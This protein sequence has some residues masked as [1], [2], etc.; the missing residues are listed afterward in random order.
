VIKAVK[1]AQNLAKK[2]GKNRNRIHKPDITQGQDIKLNNAGAL[3]A[4]SNSLA[5]S[6]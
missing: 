4:L 5:I 3:L 6:Q 1:I 2:L